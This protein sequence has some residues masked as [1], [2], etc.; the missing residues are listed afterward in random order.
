MFPDETKYFTGNVLKLDAMIAEGHLADGNFDDLYK[1][2][3][4]LEGTIF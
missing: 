3:G 4:K 2:L 1:Q